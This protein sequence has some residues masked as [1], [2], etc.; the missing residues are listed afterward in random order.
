MKRRFTES[1]CFHDLL[2]FFRLQRT[3]GIHQSSSGR[4]LLHC[5][6]Q[7]RQLAPVQVGEILGLQS[8]LDLGIV[9]QSAG[10]GAGHVGQNAIKAR[11]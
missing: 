11:A 5:R 2:I 6:P 8:P 1:A 9:R 10:A 4:D 3:S 7:N